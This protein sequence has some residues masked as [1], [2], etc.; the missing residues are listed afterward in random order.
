MPEQNIIKE[1]TKNDDTVIRISTTQFRGQEYID[2][3]SY[4]KNQEG[5]YIPTKKGI[6]LSKSVLPEVLAALQQIT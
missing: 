1:I 3:R 2:I 6:T 5:E 4:V